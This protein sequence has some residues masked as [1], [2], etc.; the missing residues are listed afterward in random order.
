MMWNGE[1]CLAEK[2]APETPSTAAQ[3]NAELMKGAHGLHWPYAQLGSAGKS[4]GRLCRSEV[5]TIR[6]DPKLRYLAEL[7]ARK[8][9]R[10]LSSFIEWAIEQSLSEVEFTENSTLADNAAALWDVDECDRFVKLA[11]RDENL[12]NYQEQ[13]VWK[14]LQ[15][16]EDP[17]ILAKDE[18]K[19][20][21]TALREFWSDIEEAKRSG[22]T[23]ATARAGKRKR[24]GHG[25]GVR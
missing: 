2:K 20:D 15:A 13:V 17:G 9:R 14:M 12:L 7:A 10:T 1:S 16:L 6:L 4:G 24:P 25:E 22:K 19:I 3:L 23:V 21:W 18:R 11:L 5:V 8:Q